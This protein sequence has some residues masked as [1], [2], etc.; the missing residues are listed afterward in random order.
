VKRS[1]LLAVQLLSKPLAVPT[2]SRLAGIAYPIVDE[3]SGKI[4]PGLKP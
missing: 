2:L 1:R 3:L 4:L